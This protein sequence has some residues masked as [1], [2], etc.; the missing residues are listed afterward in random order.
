MLMNV[1]QMPH[2][3]TL[4]GTSPVPVTKDTLEMEGVVVVSHYYERKY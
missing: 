3:P 2:V 1:T 4:L